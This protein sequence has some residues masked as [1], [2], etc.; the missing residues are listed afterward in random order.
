MIIY[1]VSGVVFLS[2]L[3]N[4]SMINFFINLIEINYQN[5]GKDRVLY[6]FYTEL[7]DNINE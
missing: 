2:L 3:I 5:I 6:N 7:K 1:H 4:C